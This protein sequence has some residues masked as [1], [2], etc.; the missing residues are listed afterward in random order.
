M[1]AVCESCGNSFVPEIGTK[2]EAT[3]TVFNISAGRVYEVVG[4]ARMFGCVVITDDLGGEAEYGLKYFSL[5][6][7]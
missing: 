2:I 5:I 6:P 4:Y 1:K 3:F 7:K